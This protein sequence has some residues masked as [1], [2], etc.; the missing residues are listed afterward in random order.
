MEQYHAWVGEV[1]VAISYILAHISYTT[2]KISLESSED[3]GLG[4]ILGGVNNHLKSIMVHLLNDQRCLL[5]E[6]P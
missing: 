3:I 1:F 4:A 5:I 2:S 6:G